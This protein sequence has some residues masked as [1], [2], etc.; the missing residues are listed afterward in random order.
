MVRFLAT[1]MCPPDVLV[2]VAIGR[3]SGRERVGGGGRAR[4]LPAIRPDVRVLADYVL[5]RIPELR[6]LFLFVGPF[7]S[8]RSVSRNIASLREAMRWVERGGALQIQQPGPRLRIR[9]ARMRV[10]GEVEVGTPPG[11]RGAGREQATNRVAD[12]GWNTEEV[13]GLAAAFVDAAPER[14]FAVALGQA[15]WPGREW[16]EDV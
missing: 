4:R 13:D 16:L 10:L 15:F 11:G 12:V 3:A 5:E 7:G 14:L 1:W 8:P 6:E 9:C 2:T